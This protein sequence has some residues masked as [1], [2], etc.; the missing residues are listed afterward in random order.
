MLYLSV[1][2]RWIVSRTANDVYFGCAIASLWL[3]ATLIGVRAA[4]EMSGPNALAEAPLAA[5]LI[6]GLLWPGIV[7]SGLLRVAMWY[8]WFSFDHSGWVKR[9]VW[10]LVWF[11]GIT[12]GPAFY[13]FFVYRRRDEDLKSF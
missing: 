7:G 3:L 12:V 9:A 1:T 13:Y 10:F 6:K 5:L 11:L 2:R 4:L 8:F